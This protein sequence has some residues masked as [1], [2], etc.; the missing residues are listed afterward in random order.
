V[1]ATTEI[2]AARPILPGRPTPYL[3]SL[4]LEDTVHVAGPSGLVDAVKRK[5]RTA[6]ARCYADAF[7][8]SVQ[9]PSLVD[10]VMQMLRTPAGEAANADILSPRPRGRLGW[11]FRPFA[12]AGARQAG[13]SS[14]ILRPAPST[15]IQP[16][17]ATRPGEST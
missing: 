15:A 2:D 6:A 9:A 13:T 7:L 16:R 12:G 11:V 4:G 14:R 10:R 3:P 17:P 5:A 8:P 1:I